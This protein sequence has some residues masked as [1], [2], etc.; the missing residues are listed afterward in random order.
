M[1]FENVNGRTSH[2]EYYLSK[3]E[4][5]DCNVKI[6]GRNFFNQPVTNSIKTYENIRKNATFQRDD[7]TTCCLL[8]YPYSKENINK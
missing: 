2:E 7:Y 6:D 8:D 4:I 1:S 3:K 5:K